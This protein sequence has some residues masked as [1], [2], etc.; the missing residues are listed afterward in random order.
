MTPARAHV[1]AFAALAVLVAAE[2]VLRAAHLP[3]ALRVAVLGA[4]AV[5]TFAVIVAYHMN[6]RSE[7]RALQ[8]M[9]VLPLTLPTLY[10]V[11]LVA[12]ALH[13]AIRP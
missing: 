1:L 11:A 13:P 5:A 6:L 7:S 10:A 9:F 4:L 8:L 3:P 12:E 2:L